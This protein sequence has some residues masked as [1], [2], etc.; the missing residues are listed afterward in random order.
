MQEIW[1]HGSTVEIPSGS[2]GLYWDYIG[3]IRGL[4]WKILGV[5]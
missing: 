2:V 4:Y 1:L 5:I 3:I